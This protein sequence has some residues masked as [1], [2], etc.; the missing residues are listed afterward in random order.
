[1][2]P[3]S[4]KLR[5]RKRCASAAAAAAAGVARGSAKTVWRRGANERKQNSK[6]A[7]AEQQTS[8]NGTSAPPAETEKA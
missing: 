2:A 7:E 4:A 8:G 6:R 1:M 3:P 5:K